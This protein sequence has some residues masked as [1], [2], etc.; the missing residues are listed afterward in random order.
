MPLCAGVTGTTVSALKLFTLRT[1]LQWF[2][3]VF[4]G[5]LQGA[6]LDQF[7]LVSVRVFH[8]RNHG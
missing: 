3:V 8:K 1:G 7:D 4:R 5:P 6:F 2:T